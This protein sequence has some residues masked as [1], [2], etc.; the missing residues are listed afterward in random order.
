[1]DI[2]RPDAEKRRL[3]RWALAIAAGVAGVVLAGLAL[4]L[5]NRAPA[6]ESDKI[7]TGTVRRE[8]ML[9]EVAANGTLIAPEVRTITNRNEA[10]VERVLVLP[11]H[12]VEP[13]DVLVT[14]SSPQLEEE[15]SDARL[16]VQAAEADAVLQ[17][18]ELENKYFDSMAQLANA[19]AEYTSA[20]L[21]MDAHQRL[22]EQSASSAIEVQ[23]TKLR[24]ESWLKRLDAERARHASFEEY[25]KA[26][27]HSTDAQLSQSRQQVE[28]LKRDVADL[29]IRAGVRGVVQEINAV[30]GERLVAGKAIA[31]VVNPDHLIARVQVSE[32]DAAQVQL[33]MP[34]T[35]SVGQQQLTGK[36]E[37]VAP[38]V[39][40]QLVEVDVFLAR[41]SAGLRPDLTVI[42][43]IELA[44]IAD[45]L[46]LERPAGLSDESEHMELF[47]VTDDQ[48]SASRQSVKI[49]R[50]STRQ[51]EVLAGLEPGDTVILSD[52]A[53]FQDAS[54]LRIL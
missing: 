15:L 19:E 40:D 51:V 34:V 25:R 30:A 39:R 29:H 45:A 26:K 11:G 35:V 41:S 23:R 47:R 42:A 14:T 10:I 13:D 5:S 6:I 38:T 16:R 50:R 33:G 24:A 12:T 27:R 8:E 2:R 43:R 46:V 32:R 20:K 44:R 22:A 48:D 18:V 31:K 36:V 49:G 28:R 21:E 52:L 4:V 7:W 1:M 54:A 9:L 17:R 37:R 53:D 3:R